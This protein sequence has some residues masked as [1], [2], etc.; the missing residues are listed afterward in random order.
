MTRLVSG[1]LC[2]ADSDAIV[3]GG[4]KKEGCKV[5]LRG[6]PD[7]RGWLSTLI[8]QGRLWESEKQNAIIC[9][10]LAAIA[11]RGW[12]VLLELKRGR[13]DAAQVVK[14]LRAGAGAAEDL[15]P[16]GVPVRFRPV[17]ATGS[18]PKAERQ[19]LRRIGNIR[20]RGQQEDVRLMSCGAPIAEVLSR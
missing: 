5:S 6:A 7:I 8:G 19:K 9:W 20:F 17:A 4:L 12:L 3:K 15:V 16:V 13:L 18:T 10:R 2:K 11:G 1:I 14:Q